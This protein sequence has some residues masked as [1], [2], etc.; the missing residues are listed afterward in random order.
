MPFNA[1]FFARRLK[2]KRA[3]MGWNQNELAEASGVSLGTVA[4]YEMCATKPS[5]ETI[6]DLAD[7]LE[8]STDDF[9]ERNER[10]AS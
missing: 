8:C 6:C 3:E 9:W 5:F 10:K 1:E 7:A 2:V 4:R